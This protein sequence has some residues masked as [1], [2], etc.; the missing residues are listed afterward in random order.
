M[1]VQVRGQSTAEVLVSSQG[2]VCMRQKWAQ[3][4]GDGGSGS[5]HGSGVRVV[6]R[7]LLL[8]HALTSAAPAYAAE[9]TTRGT[10]LQVNVA[11]S[12]ITELPG[13]GTGKL[14]DVNEFEVR[15]RE[16]VTV[17]IVDHNPLLF[18]YETTISEAETEQ[19]KIAA[20]FAK[21]LNALMAGFRSGGGGDAAILVEG[22]NLDTLRVQLQLLA[23]HMTSIGA[24]IPKSL[25]SPADIASLK[26]TVR[27]WT[28]TTFTS[29]LAEDLQ[30]VAV[31]A[32][33][34]L[35]GDVL[36]TNAEFTFHCTSPLA[37]AIKP[38]GTLRAEREARQKEAAAAQ[39]AARQSQVRPNRP[40]G[41]KPPPSSAPTLPSTELAPISG[42]TPPPAG[43]TPLP[44]A[45]GPSRPG[46]RM[47]PGDPTPAVSPVVAAPGERII[48]FITLIE[49]RRTDLQNSMAVLRTFA[50]DVE[51][52]HQPKTLTT[53]NHSTS[54]QTIAIVVKASPKY[55]GFI[56]AGTKKRRDAIARKFSVVL[57]PYAPAMISLAPALV[58]LFIDNPTFKAVKRGD[59]FVIEETDEEVTGYNLG[60]MLNIT[61]RQWSEPTFGGAFQVGVSPTKNKIGF[62]LGGGI[63]VQEVF[64]FG[65]GFTWQEVNKLAGGLTTG[66]VLASPDELKTAT[67]FKPGFYFHITANLK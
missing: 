54:T 13:G 60:A 52:V 28:V 57:Q 42:G 9:R 3:V 49:A 25:G 62:Y 1:R 20:E 39:E 15:K 40:G 41:A 67:R 66:Q 34:C 30:K 63:S 21:A 14:L 11:E 58:L 12:V 17:D 6:A 18:E 32:G 22:V 36:S 59:Q 5:R 8:C 27:G 7:S 35:A 53:R 23:T 10:V 47:L 19:H 44:V 43:G 45:P 29:R 16:T 46:P 38:L 31:I 24:E 37:D 4:A 61:P 64:W 55:E 50:Q 51:A 33:K 56:D 2:A 48:D 65:G 26:A